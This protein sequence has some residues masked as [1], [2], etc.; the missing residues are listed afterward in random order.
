MRWPYPSDGQDPWYD[1][2][3][4][5]VS[6]QDA[7]A[8]AGFEDRNTFI[9]GG[10]TF[11]FTAATGE[12]EWTA[13]IRIVLPSTGTTQNATTPLVVTLQDGQCAYVLLDR[14]STAPNNLAVLTAFALP[15]VNRD[16]ILVLFIRVGA[17]IHFRNGLVLSDGDPVEVFDGPSS[18]GGGFDNTIELQVQGNPLGAVSTINFVGG[19]VPSGSVVAGTA[20]IPI[21]AGLKSE[22]IT[23]TPLLIDGSNIARAFY[24]T[25]MGTDAE[26]TLPPSGALP[27][28]LFFVKNLLV[29]HKVTLFPRPPDLIEGETSYVLES[30]N[31]EALFQSAGGSWFVVTEKRLT[32]PAGIN[33]E[34]QFNDN[35]NFGAS[36]NLLWNA[37]SIT[38]FV[39]GILD[40]SGTIKSETGLEILNDRFVVNALGDITRLNSIDTSFPSIQGDPGTVLTNDGSGG[41][42]WEEP[43]VTPPG[44][45]ESSLQFR[46]G[47]S[48]S[49]SANLLWDEVLSELTVTGRIKGLLT[50]VDPTEAANKQYVDDAIGA[51]TFTVITVTNADPIPLE[52][53]VVL[54]NGPGGLA[55]PL[56][57][58][59]GNSGKQLVVKKIDANAADE[60]VA[61]GTETIDGESSLP[62]LIQWEARTLISDGSNWF[63]I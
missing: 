62:L 28:Q 20:T 50:P 4:A 55:I 19:S 2:F 49:G 7:S 42:T 18:G 16:E 14:G 1:A 27:D 47:T 31:D 8:Y 43:Y 5:M 44:G 12:V 22:A 29:G 61:D 11:T 21:S 30:Y 58:A 32:N 13:P 53:D 37:G 60:L 54:V 3:A 40:V 48:F 9:S 10:G 56:P 52:A 36:P 17:R 23:T 15:P 38:L 6:S 57:P 25:G 51:L 41:L 34:L 45:P 35:G 39:D 46:S 59:S 63:I 26:V 33:G 24:V